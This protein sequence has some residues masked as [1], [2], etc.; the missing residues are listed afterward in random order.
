MQFVD[1]DRR[2]LPVPRRTLRQPGGVIPD[3]LRRRRDIG[4]GARTQFET[5]AIG[6]GLDQFL[7]AVAIDDFE[8][9]QACLLYTSRCV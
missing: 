4:G 5:A 2:V 9:V 3:V 6:V 8:A 7:A 1:I